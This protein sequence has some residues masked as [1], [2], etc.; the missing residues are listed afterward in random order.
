MKKIIGFTLL[1]VVGMIYIFPVHAANRVSR[2]HDFDLD[3]INE[4]EINNSVGSIE[5]RIGDDDELHVDIDIESGDDGFF[6][7]GKDVDD[8]DLDIRRRGD[9][10]ILTI[11]ED[12]IKADWY[13]ELPA[14]NAID[15]DMGVGELDIEIG[16]SS[17]AIDLGVGEIDVLAPLA[18]TGDIEISAGVGDTTIRGINSVE[19]KRSFVSSKSEGRGEGELSIDV[20]VGVGD[21]T[22]SLD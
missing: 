19:N 7:R 6:R 1:L 20:E 22:V 15:I 21:V 14:L 17:L 8:I 10:L 4:L 9:K 5:M 2:N 13:I 12:N 16:A 3:D 18:S 11:D